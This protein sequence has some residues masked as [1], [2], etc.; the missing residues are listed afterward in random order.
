MA[1]G[2]GTRRTIRFREKMDC[3]ILSGHRRVRPFGLAGGEAGQIGENAVRR[4]DG[5]IES[6]QGCDAAMIDADEAIIIRCRRPADTARP[7][8]VKKVSR[9]DEM[10]RTGIR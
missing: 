6:L 10:H 5:S 1:A 4:K 3:S 8:A 9:R 2:D 7:D